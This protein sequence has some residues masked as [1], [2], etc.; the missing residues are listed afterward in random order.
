M[1]SGGKRICDVVVGVE[2]VWCKTE[3]DHPESERVRIIVLQ[4]RRADFFDWLRRGR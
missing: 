4:I 1:V 2:C 3:K